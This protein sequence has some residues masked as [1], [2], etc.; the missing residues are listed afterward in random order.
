MEDGLVLSAAKRDR[1]A[2]DPPVTECRSPICRLSC[3]YTGCRAAANVQLCT[4]QILIDIKAT[5]EPNGGSAI[6]LSDVIRHLA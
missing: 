4:R 5:S 6:V 1:G 3:P 2:A